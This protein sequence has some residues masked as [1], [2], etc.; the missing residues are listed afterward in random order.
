[1]HLRALLSIGAA[2]R[3]ALTV[4]GGGSLDYDAL[5]RNVDALALEL[6]R[7]GIEPGDRVAASLPNGLPLVLA[8]F[9]TACARAA[10]APLN[11]A[12]TRDEYAF[13]LDDIG[14]K[15]I[16]VPPGG[17]PLAREAAASLGIAVL[18]IALDAAGSL[19]LDGVPLPPGAPAAGPHDDDAAL[20][21]HTSGTT[22]R[23]KGVPLTHRNLCA[24]ARNIVR[25]YEIS[26]D[27][28][29][30]CVMPLFHV[31]GLVFSTLATLYAGASE[32]VVEKFSARR[33]G[34]RSSNSASRS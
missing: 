19:T 11:P 15:A 16:F 29:S 24:S 20:F 5:R 31:H 23:P 8:F 1:M 32:I 7:R 30:L 27:D 22:S 25:W 21:L 9:A 6:G 34:R 12:Y 10:S 26:A 2:R 33:S 4:P 3:P 13:Y 18:E 14:P 28:V 17:Q